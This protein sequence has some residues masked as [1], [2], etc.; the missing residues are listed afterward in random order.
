MTYAPPDTEWANSD[1]EWT[2]SDTDSDSDGPPQQERRAREPKQVQWDP[3]VKENDAQRQRSAKGNGQGFVDFERVH[4]TREPNLREA[5][6]GLN[7]SPDNRRRKRGLAEDRHTPEI[8]R[9]P[10]QRATPTADERS[11]LPMDLPVPLSRASPMEP[12]NE[13]WKTSPSADRSRES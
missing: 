10:P 9:T 12:E 11:P 5:R 7:Y 8:E 1:D 6:E 3:T 4:Q 2:D 13:P